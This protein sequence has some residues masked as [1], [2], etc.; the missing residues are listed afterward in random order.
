MPVTSSAAPVRLLL[1]T[2][3]LDDAARQGRF[4]SARPCPGHEG[5]AGPDL[6]AWA[7]R[8]LEEVAAEDP[9][10]VRSWLTDPDYAPPGGG[11]SV[12]ALI[13][14]TGAH[15][16]ALEPGRHHAVVAQAVVRAVVVAALELPAAA[17]WRL[18]VRPDT[19]TALSGRAGRWNLLVGAPPSQQPGQH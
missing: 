9:Q 16:A 13:A 4:G 8:T 14:R 5:L 11:E 19:V 17:F 12:A 1:T 6:G 7:G 2:P 10:G 15:L 18:D 3:P